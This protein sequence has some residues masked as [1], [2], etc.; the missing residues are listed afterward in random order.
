M[1]SFSTCANV[2]PP[3]VFAH[4]LRSRI[5]GTPQLRWTKVVELDG[6][7]A[8]PPPECHPSL[9]VAFAVRRFP[10]H[11][12]HSL[13]AEGPALPQ[14]LQRHQPPYWILRRYWT[15]WPG[16][17]PMLQTTGYYFYHHWMV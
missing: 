13:L 1:T 7:T 14:A 11:G 16:S 10:P 2:R 3:Y 4:Q 8:H 5:H 6:P 17:L 15:A 9:P 12:S